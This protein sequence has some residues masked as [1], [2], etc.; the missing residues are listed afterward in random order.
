MLTQR[1]T[2]RPDQASAS[3]QLRWSV[4]AAAELTG[5]L[6]IFSAEGFSREPTRNVLFPLEPLLRAQWSI[7]TNRCFFFIS[8]MK[9]GTLSNCQDATTLDLLMG[10]NSTELGVFMESMRSVH[11]LRYG[12]WQSILHHHGSSPTVCQSWACPAWCTR[13]MKLTLHSNGA[14]LIL[15]GSVTALLLS[16]V[17]WCQRC[18]LMSQIWHHVSHVFHHVIL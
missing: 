6:L 11:A 16:Q 7:I 3:Q 1:E 14:L 18:H 10:V 5:Q 13:A 8:K 15:F 12:S 17:K 9:L 2:G 4:Y